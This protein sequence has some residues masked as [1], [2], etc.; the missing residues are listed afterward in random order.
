MEELKSQEYLGMRHAGNLPRL[1]VNKT[2]CRPA[3]Q[4]LK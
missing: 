1:Q 3:C 2:G 4:G